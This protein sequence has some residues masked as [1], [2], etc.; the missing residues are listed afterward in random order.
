MRIRLDI[1]LLLSEIKAAVGSSERLAFDREIKYIS[2]DTR[3]LEETDLFIPFAGRNFNGE[4]FV[5]EALKKGAASLSLKKLNGTVKIQSSEDAL[6][7][8]ARLYKSKLKSLRCTVGITGSVGKSTVKEFTRSILQKKYN[9]HASE[10]NFNNSLGSCL[11][12]LSASKDTEILVLE[13][14]MNHLGEICEMSKAFRPKLGV[15]TN[16]GSSHIGNLGSREAISR[17]KLEILDGMDENGLLIPFEEP[18]LFGKG[19]YSFSTSDKSAEFYLEKTNKTISFYRNGTFLFKGVF[20]LEEEH[21]KECLA[22]AVALSVLNGISNE[23]LSDAVSQLGRECVRSNFR[24]I[25]PLTLY[26]DHYNASF[27][28]LD[29]AFEFISGLKGFSRK[30]ALLGSVLELGTSAEKIHFNI[31]RRAA[32]SNFYRLY[33]FGEY[34]KNIM[35][36]ALSEGFAPKNII[37]FESG[38]HSEAAQEILKNSVENELILVKGSRAMRLEKV[39]QELIKRT[40]HA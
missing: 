9:V 34:A 6:F 40:D 11:S 14:G 39:T 33:L 38:S 13:M 18:L 26:E 27:E 8:I 16:I 22:P 30:S 10:G 36:G 28:S 31:G 3:E 29:A 35:D 32:L 20:S 4:D 17:A 15:I 37:L 24:R 12:I 2:T 23:E 19:K 5:F 7:D 1:P 21:F 25:E